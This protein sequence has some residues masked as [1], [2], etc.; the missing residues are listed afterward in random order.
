MIQEVYKDISDA[1][2]LEGNRLL[3]DILDCDLSTLY[4]YPEQVIDKEKIEIIKDCL[5]KRKIGM[6]YAYIMKKQFFYGR[7]FYV[8]QRVLIP[9][10]ETELSVIEI[11]KLINESKSKVLEIGV[12]S[13]AVAITLDLETPNSIVHGVDISEDALNI[14][15]KNNKILSGNVTFWKSDLF[16]DVEE[17]YDIIYSNPPYIESDTLMELSPSV[18]QY[19]PRLALDGGI[20]G[21][22]FYRKIIEDGTFFL[23]KDGYF[24]FEIGYNQSE[25]IRTILCHRGFSHI[26]II[27]DYQGY[28]RVLIA[29]R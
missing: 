1:S 12:G 11:C 23:N 25:R 27:K 22:D 8:D 10:P 13:G 16:Y 17:T 15:R 20:D 6:P 26:K 19:E 21:L 4:S 2:P 5:Q 14:A 18:I 24:I 9:R 3:C 7:S 29:W 28:D